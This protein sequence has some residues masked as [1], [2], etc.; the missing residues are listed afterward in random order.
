MQLSEAE[1]R[2]I[3][4]GGEEAV[5][6]LVSQL[7]ERLNSLEAEVKELKG[8]LNQD[9]RNNSSKSPS[10]ETCAGCGASLATVPVGR[11]F[12]PSRGGYSPRR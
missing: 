12:G 11:Y 7:L 2:A 5:V 3:Y 9:S 1:I 8:R 6:S 4:A 10:V